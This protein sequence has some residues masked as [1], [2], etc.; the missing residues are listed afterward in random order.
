MC[1]GLIFVQAANR[2]MWVGDNRVCLDIWI[3]AFYKV[4]TN[5]ENEMNEKSTYPI[6]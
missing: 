6:V 5:E 4:L 3:I 2:L 1:K